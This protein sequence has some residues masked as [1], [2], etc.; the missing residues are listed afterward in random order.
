MLIKQIMLLV[1]MADISVEIIELNKSKYALKI[2]NKE[3]T[4]TRQLLSL[5]IREKENELL[6]RNIIL[7]RLVIFEKLL[8]IKSVKTNQNA[9]VVRKL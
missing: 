7:K 4:L 3:E 6:G 5:P 9:N 8:N 2:R 1:I